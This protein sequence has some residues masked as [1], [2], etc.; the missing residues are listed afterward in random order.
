MRNITISPPLPISLFTTATVKAKEGGT[1]T[2]VE[3]ANPEIPIMTENND[4]WGI[5]T[6][7][8]TTDGWNAPQPAPSPPLSTVG[9]PRANNHASLHWMACYNDYCSAHCQMKDDNYYPQWGNDRCC[10]THRPCNCTNA[11]PFELVEVIHIRHLN[12]RKA[13]ADWRK[14]KQVCPN[15]R[16]LVHMED[17]HQRCQTMAQCTPLTDITPALEE[18]ELPGPIEEDQENL[19]AAAVSTTPQ[20]EQLALL[21]EII[22]MIHQTTTPDTRCKHVVHRTLAQHMNE[23]LDADQQRLQ[24]TIRFLA[25]IVIERQR[26]NEQLQARQQGSRTVRIYCTHI[27][28]HAAHRRHDLAGASAWTGD[29]LSQISRCRLVSADARADITLAALWLALITTAAPTVILRA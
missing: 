25:E 15:C 4:N 27:F 22:T 29:I 28:R 16:F 12:S 5:P 26:L 14:G 1:F 18:Q 24:G 6:N 20:E 19:A 2:N 9:Q 3:Q 8:T 17:H 7:A 11:H 21:G 10:Q 23:L 13:C